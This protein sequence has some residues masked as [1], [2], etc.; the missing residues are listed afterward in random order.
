MARVPTIPKF[1]ILVAGDSHC[2]TWDTLLQQHIMKLPDIEI[3]L[4]SCPGARCESLTDRIAMNS[5]NKEY[6]ILYYSAGINELS[7]KI[8]GHRGHKGRGG[9][10]TTHSRPAIQEQPQ[11]TVFPCTTDVS[12]VCS[13]VRDTCSL[14]RMNRSTIMPSRKASNVDSDPK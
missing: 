5:N 7:V 11:Q 4:L 12:A 6:D 10:D 14:L 2:R 9:V 1:R 3:T 13:S 8:K